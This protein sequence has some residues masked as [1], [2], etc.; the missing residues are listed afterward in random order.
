MSKST[1]TEAIQ[2]MENDTSSYHPKR[3]RKPLLKRVSLFGWWWEVGAIFVSFTTTGLIF[4]TL[5]YMNGRPL[6]DYRLPIQLNS[7]IAVFSTLARSALMLTLADGLS[8]LK[9]NHF[10]R[11]R[12][13]LSQL[14]TYD[15]ASR[16]PWGA[17]M[18]LVS[19][20]KD[21]RGVAALGAVLTI[22]ALAFEP[23]T[24]QIVE[25]EPRQTFASNATAYVNTATNFLG[26]TGI[27][28][29]G[30]PLQASVL[31]ALTDSL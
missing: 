11:R 6:S 18:Y 21:M 28:E 15:N 16:G 23:F 9:W 22:L 27:R 3:P 13:L 2:E 26:A 31:V 4:V 29:Q 30:M 10:E 14:Q 17:V 24:Q 25:F 1:Y 8:Q 5:F 19:M 12:S 7:L 20:W